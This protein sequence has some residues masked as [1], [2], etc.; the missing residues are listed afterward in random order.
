[1]RVSQESNRSRNGSKLRHTAPLSICFVL[2]VCAMFLQRE[3][4]LDCIT[5]IVHSTNKE[6]KWCGSSLIMLLLYN[7]Y[8]V[9][10][11]PDGLTCPDKCDCD[12]YH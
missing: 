5:Y 2:T 9:K 7:T 6:E 4:A 3:E 8:F 12:V 1:M 11:M 10:K